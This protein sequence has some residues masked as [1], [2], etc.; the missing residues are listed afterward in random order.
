MDK[1]G[2]FPKTN[3]NEMF[4]NICIFGCDKESTYRIYDSTRVCL[5]TTCPFN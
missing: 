3:I 1:L 4:G 2:I 5:H